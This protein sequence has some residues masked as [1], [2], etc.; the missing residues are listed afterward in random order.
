MLSPVNRLALDVGD[1]ADA[2]AALVRAP[3]CRVERLKQVYSRLPNDG[4]RPRYDY[5]AP[6]FDFRTVLTCDRLGF[7]LDYP[8]I[9]V[10]VAWANRL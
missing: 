1:V 6:E 7:V 9:A 8:G 3:T 2:P 10:R 5:A 4:E